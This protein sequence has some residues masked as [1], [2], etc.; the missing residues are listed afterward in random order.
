PGKNRPQTHAE[1][2]RARRQYAAMR[3]HGFRGVRAM[4][5][6]TRNDYV[7]ALRVLARIEAQAG[8]VD[9]FAHAAVLAL[10]GYVACERTTLSV[11]DLRTGHL[12]VLGLPGVH[13]GS[14]ERACFERHFFEP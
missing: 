13:L 10:N 1:A 14:D 7:S 8:D 4:N 9:C 2:A 5:H 12:Q 11:C 6:L 3:M